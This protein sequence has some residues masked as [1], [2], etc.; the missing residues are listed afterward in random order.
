MGTRADKIQETKSKTNETRV[1]QTQ[2][3]R[4]PTFEFVDNR[5]ET[6]NQRNFQA[7][8]NNIKQS[9]QTIQSHICEGHFTP[10]QQQ[11]VQKKGYS[12]GLAVKK[13]E[14]QKSPLQR[15]RMLSTGAKV[16]EQKDMV[17]KRQLFIRHIERLEKLGQREKAETLREQLKKYPELTDEEVIF[18]PVAIEQEPSTAYALWAHSAS[19]PYY[20]FPTSYAKQTEEVDAALANGRYQF[21]ITV[22]HPSEVLVGTGGHDALAKHGNVWYAGTVY[23]GQGQLEKWN[24]DTGHYRTSE[25]YR[26]QALRAPTDDL[27]AGLLPLSKFVVFK[28]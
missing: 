27:S 11:P 12:I 3:G 22:E 5:S 13:S 4:E 15:G 14:K 7:M 17:E 28:A 23:F 2:R 6:I 20:I 26:A 10:Q 1:S 19:G 16:L 25:E 24:N 18:Q 9:R 8:A 21:V